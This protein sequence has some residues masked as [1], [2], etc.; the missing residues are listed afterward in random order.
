MSMAVAAIAAVAVM[1]TIPMV[2]IEA[3]LGVTLVVP[4]PSVA[5][6][7]R[8]EARLP[9]SPSGGAHDSPTWL[10]LEGSGGAVARLEVE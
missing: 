5:E 9:V 7:E 10:E 4:P 1:A 6:E 8:R 3:G 2:S